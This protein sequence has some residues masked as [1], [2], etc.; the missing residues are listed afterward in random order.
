MVESLLH[1]V[2]LVCGLGLLWVSYGIV[3]FKPILG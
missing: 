3:H 2:I 1:D